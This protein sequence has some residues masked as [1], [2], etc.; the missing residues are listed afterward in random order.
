VRQVGEGAAGHTGYLTFA[1]LYTKRL[2][3]ADAVAGKLLVEEDAL[4]LIDRDA[5]ED[6]DGGG[7][8]G[9]GGDGDDDDDDEDSGDAGARAGAG[10][11]ER[12]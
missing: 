10:E 3:S 12:A 7:G 5:G 6:D 4:G 11:G 2:S 8:G 1:M 9:G